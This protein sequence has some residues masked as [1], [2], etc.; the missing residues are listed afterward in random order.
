MTDIEKDWFLFLEE[1][2]HNRYSRL[3]KFIR[4]RFSLMGEYDNPEVIKYVEC[5][6][7]D[8]CIFGEPQE[9]TQYLSKKN[10]ADKIDE[11]IENVS[12]SRRTGIAMTY[13]EN[14]RLCKAK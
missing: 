4:K 6:L 10:L 9:A 14:D 11:I 13:W 8:T 1:T 12:H 7:F 2:K 3:N 5:V